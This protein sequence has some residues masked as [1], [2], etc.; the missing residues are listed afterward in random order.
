MGETNG[1]IPQDKK[2][3][4][5]F[6]RDV[7][8]RMNEL[9]MMVDLS[10]VGEQTFKDAMS[11]TTKP[12]I[13]SHSCA[14]TL[15][16]VF[17]NLK[18]YQI[19]AVGKNGGVICINFFSGFVDSNFFK[20]QNAFLEIHKAEKDSLLKS[21]QQQFFVEDYL[22]QKYATEVAGLR[23]PLSMLIDHIDYIVKRIGADHVGLGSDFDG[24]NSAPQGLNGIEDFPKIT[25]AL[26]QRG[27]SNEG[28]FK[29][30]GRKCCAGIQGKPAQINYANENYFSC[31][32]LLLQFEINAQTTASRIDSLMKSEAEGKSF[33]GVLLVAEKGKPVYYKAY[34]Y[35]DFAKKI[36]LSATDIFELASV[37]KQFT[38]M[39]IMML[40]E[41]KQLQYDDPVEKYL[42]IP[43][44]GITIRHLLTHTSG[45]P[46]Y[47]EI[48]DKY[49]DKTKV[50]GNADAIEYL[51]KYNP[52]ALFE[53]GT[54]YT[55]S[56]TGY[57][58]LA[59]IAEKVTG[60]DFIEL[61]RQWIFIPLKM[62]NTDIRSL[63][64]KA[65]VSNFAIG[66][67][68]VK[69]QARYIRADSFPSSDYTIWL[70]NRKGPGRVSS[71]AG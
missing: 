40:K 30:T 65:A 47:Q 2:G 4:S 63:E 48:M 67:V 61:C 54:K 50:A 49:W 36:P 20:R 11:V 62:K 68:Y 14:W 12:V 43:Y 7:V 19:D 41:K 57:L 10:H 46:D 51:N 6:G 37:S 71:T 64:A 70:G 15:A 8:K 35:R 9:G 16:P 59:S 60:R 21:G 23:P 58:L 55:Y 53:P 33:S 25:A 1:S 69:E 22:F 31:L 34:G 17:R 56:N 38:S 26:K 66:H 28:H 29:N 13:V 32:P 24:I 5:P 27:Y 42:H 3:L 18:D 52:P 44:K 39:I 45:L